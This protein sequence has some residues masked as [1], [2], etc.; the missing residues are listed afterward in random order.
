M[1]LSNYFIRKKVRALAAKSN[2]RM[3][4]FCNLEDA[5]QIFVLYNAEDKS[6]VASFLQ[7]LSE[8]GKQVR[9]C[10]YISDKTVTEETNA[11]MLIHPETDLDM[12]YIPKDPVCKDFNS[13]KAD[14]LIDLT[15]SD[16]YVMHYLLLQHPCSFKVG[17]KNVEADL[18]D[19]SIS[20]TNGDDIKHLFEQILFYLQSI[21][22]K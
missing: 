5:C 15:R 11:S 20:M 9:T 14:I 16:N 6:I 2:K 22:S 13:H 7:T 19:F 21:R 17:A 1:K 4:R 18:Y 12:W 8:L 3:P 10:I